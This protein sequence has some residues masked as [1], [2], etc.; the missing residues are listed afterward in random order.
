MSNLTLT[1][2]RQIGRLVRKEYERINPR[3]IRFSDDGEVTVM[4]DQMPNTNEPG[5][6]FIGWATDWLRAVQ[7]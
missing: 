5:R 3:N 4:V 6:I 2:K 1:E 7:K